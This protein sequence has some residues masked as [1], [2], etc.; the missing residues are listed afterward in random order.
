MCVCVF[1]YVCVQREKEY[2]LVT[3]QMNLSYFNWSYLPILDDTYT[4]KLIAFIKSIASYIIIMDL[5]N[6]HYK[7]S[8]LKFLSE[9]Q[10]DFF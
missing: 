4:S 10:K 8:F 3:N 5:H 6:C 1:V 7:G 9:M 2:D